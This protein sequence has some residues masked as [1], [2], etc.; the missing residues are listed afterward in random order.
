MPF[1]KV[2]YE[3]GAVALTALYARPA[4]PARAAVAIYPTFMNTTPA[5]E[6]KAA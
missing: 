2:G 4:A 3:D 5:V 1:E 6:A